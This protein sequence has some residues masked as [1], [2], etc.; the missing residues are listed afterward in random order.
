MKTFNQFNEDASSSASSAIS[1]SGSFKGG[2]DFHGVSY[3]HG[4][5]KRPSTGL[6]GF[7]KGAA[8]R[9]GSAVKDRLKNRQGKPRP[10]GPGKQPDRK[11]QPYRSSKPQSTSPQSKERPALPQGKERPA[12]P[13]GKD[14]MVARRTAAAKQPPQHKQISARPASTAMAGSRQRPAIKPAKSN[15]SRDNMGVQKVNVRDEGPTQQKRLNPA[16][17]RQ[18]PP[19]KQRQLKAADG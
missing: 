4:F 2:S 17:Q 18:L 14:S 6:G 9:V 16:Q 1:G 8:K 15:L 3:D 7:A 5:K 11:P 19:A 13:A 12:L 10:D